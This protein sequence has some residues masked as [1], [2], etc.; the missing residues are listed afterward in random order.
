MIPS[1]VLVDH[2][3][4]ISDGEI[5][6]V[7]AAL[8]RQALE[9]VGVAQPVG[10]GTRATVR[11]G[12]PANPPTALEW[13]IGLF[14]TPD[15]PGALGYHDW[16]PRGMP[17]SK[18]FP[19]LDAGD[20]LP[21]SITASHELIEMLVDPLI[22]LC[23]QDPTGAIWAGEACDAV[24]ADHYEIDGV[25]VSNWVR[26]TYFQPPKLAP[27]YGYDHLQLVRAPLEIRP[28]GYGQTFDPRS[29]WTMQDGGQREGRKAAA[30]ARS[31]SVRRRYPS[32]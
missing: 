9:H 22:A 14:V 11:A 21:W 19:M 24:E 27:E 23:F 17:L 2:G 20:G 29:G 28:G 4:H 12:T 15:Q 10:W 16:T 7:A 25:K 6:R 30:L 31:R 3:C 18:V 32:R 1:I 13:E 5:A 8:Q 26:P